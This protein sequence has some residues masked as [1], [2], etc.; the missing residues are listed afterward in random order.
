M[1]TLDYSIGQRQKVNNLTKNVSQAVSDTIPLLGNT[2]SIGHIQA[3][4]AGL[5]N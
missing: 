5:L 4:I 1:F 2:A 3:L